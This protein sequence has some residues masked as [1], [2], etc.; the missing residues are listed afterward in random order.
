[1]CRPAYEVVAKLTADEF[2]Q[3]I[4]IV[5]RWP[6]HFPS[7]TVATLESQIP[8]PD[9]AVSIS[10]DLASGQPAAGIKPGAGGARRNNERKLD[11]VRVRAP[12]TVP[13]PD[14]STA[15]PER[16]VTTEKTGTRPGT[17]A[18]TVRRR[19]VVDDLMKLGLSVRAIAA[20]TGIPRSSVHRAMRAGARAEARREAAVLQLVTK[21]LG[22][23]FIP[24][25]GGPPG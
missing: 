4:D 15:E 8:Q 14:A 6:N 22:K 13:R 10:T 20:G 11:S 23:K 1:L 21:L 3:V 2:K 9:L 5:R 19:I 25:G 16:A 17:L 7:G 18:E 24:V 12:R